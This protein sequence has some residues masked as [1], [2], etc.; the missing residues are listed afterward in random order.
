M[1]T[2]NTYLNF[3]GTA[4]EAFNFYKSVF[5]GEFASIQ[6][7]KDA[8]GGDQLPANEQNRLMHVALPL[9]NGSMLMA[10]DIAPSMGHTLSMGNNYYISIHPASEEEGRKLFDGLSAGGEIE[11]PFE[12]MFW[13]AFFG[14][15]TDKFGVQWMVNFDPNENK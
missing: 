9:G 10:S 14:S 2:F 13:G 4:E 5:G 3:D 1:A 11:A 8:P 15:F 12:M 7:M 6:R